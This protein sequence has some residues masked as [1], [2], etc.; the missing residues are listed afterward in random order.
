MRLYPVFGP[1]GNVEVQISGITSYS[2][3]VAD[4]FDRGDVSFDIYFFTPL[5]TTKNK[6]QK[7]NLKMQNQGAIFLSFFSPF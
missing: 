1:H 3:L 5:F 7:E 2:I 6:T 4:L